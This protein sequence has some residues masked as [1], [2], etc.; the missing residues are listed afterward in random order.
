MWSNY[1]SSGFATISVSGTAVA[2]SSIFAGFLIA[3]SENYK[4]R[5]TSFSYCLLGFALSESLALFGLMVTFL[6]LSFG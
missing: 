5:V 6:L 1:L 4:Y 3:L 2:V